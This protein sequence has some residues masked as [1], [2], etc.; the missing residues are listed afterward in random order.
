[1]KLRRLGKS[2]LQ[3]SEIGLG[4]WQLGGDFGPVDADTC[5]S[6]LDATESAGINFLDTADVYGGGNSERHVGAFAARAKTKPVIATKVGRSGETYPDNYEEDNI[7]QHLV[8]SCTRLG[9]DSLDLIQLHCVPPEVLQDGTIFATME[10]M[11]AE[12]LCR[13][14][15]ASVETIDEALLC[16]QQPGLTSL[17]IIFNLYRQNAVWD[18]FDKAKAADV[19]IIV[20]LPLASGVL[21]GKFKPDQSFDA[22]D[23]R[24]YN[25]NGEMFSVGETFSGIALPQAVASLDH[26]RPHVP[27]GVSMADFALRWILDHDAVSSIIAGCSRPDQVTRNAA[28]SDIAPLTAATH[29]AL[30][31]AYRDHI[32]SLVRCPI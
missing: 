3:V 16:I 24:N 8:A 32:E 4:C 27:E 26:I 6:I 28:V 19:G 1:M 9:V 2:D 20:R 10:K 30:A 29:E 15:G 5:A 25:A 23:H 12:G 17:Q 18:L 21:S 11:K 31:T 13:N 7:R 14:W 22:S